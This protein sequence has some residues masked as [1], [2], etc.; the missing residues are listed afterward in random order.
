PN[1]DAVVWLCNEIMP[2][3]WKELPFLKV[4]LL[5]SG[6]T[7]KVKSLESERVLVTGFIHNVSP[8]FEKHRVFVAPLRFGAG[9][10]GKLGQSFEYGLPI[11]STTIGVEGM[12]LTEGKNVLIA[13]DKIAFASQ[14]INLYTN[15]SLW[16]ELAKNS[17]NA[18]HPFGPESIKSSLKNIF[19]TIGS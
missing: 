19:E 6:V 1:E 18:I 5:G 4:T 9:M 13:D 7:E 8:Y 17:E 12:G 10:K 11:V 14:I 2:L 3:V 15:S 16:N